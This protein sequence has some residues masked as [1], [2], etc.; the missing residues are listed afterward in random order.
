MEKDLHKPQAYPW[1]CR[2]FLQSLYAQKIGVDRI[3]IR[4]K[5]FGWK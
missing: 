5:D 2:G 4:A 1:I 3:E